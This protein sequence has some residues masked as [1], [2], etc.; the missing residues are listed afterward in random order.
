MDILTTN[1]DLHTHTTASDGHLSP[2]E[3][4]DLAVANQVTQLAITDHDTVMGYHHAVDYAT[5]QGVSLI[6]GIEVSTTWGAHSVHIVGL[7]FDSNHDAIKT[8]LLHQNNART[9]RYR[10]ILQ[11]LSKI[12]MPISEDELLANAGNGQ[13]GRPHIAK[14]MV[15]KGYVNNTNKAFKRYLGAG[16]IG[17]VKNGWASLSDTV[18]AINDSGGVAV[19]AHPNHYKMTHSKLMQFIDEFKACGGQGI[20]VIAGKQHPD[21]TRKFALIANKKDLLASMGSDFHRHLPYAPVVGQL[22]PLPNDV[23]PVWTVFNL[24]QPVVHTMYSHAN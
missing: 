1:S 21:I 12:G 13:I 5:Q 10:V 18:S 17:D 4:V 22:S 7:N 16:K 8:L 11:K 15:E 23:T 19:V 9:S 14:L 3:L 2:K 6:S 24:K 20:E